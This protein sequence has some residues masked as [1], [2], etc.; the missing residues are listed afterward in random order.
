MGCD[1]FVRDYAIH[2]VLPPRPRTSPHRKNRKTRITT[3]ETPMKSNSLPTYFSATALGLVLLGWTPTPATA[4]ESSHGGA[5]LLQRSA[6][7]SLSSGTANSASLLPSASSH[8]ASYVQL[9]LTRKTS[10]PP[11]SSQPVLRAVAATHGAAYLQE[12]GSGAQG[13]TLAPLK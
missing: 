7:I 3:T 10:A 12:L 1:R 5:M 11:Q 2:D 9:E 8:G 6:P 4:G 13:A